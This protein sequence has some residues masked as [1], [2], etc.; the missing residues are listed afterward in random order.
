MLGE[1][2]ENLDGGLV[3]SLD[4]LKTIEAHPN[5]IVERKAPPSLKK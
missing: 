1:C 3:F 4:Q 2:D 5:P